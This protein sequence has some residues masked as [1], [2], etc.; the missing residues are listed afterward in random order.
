MKNFLH[1]HNL[2]QPISRFIFETDGEP[3]LQSPATIEITF[4][5]QSQM[6]TVAKEGV[7]G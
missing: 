4:H 1:S 5:S 7:R 6:L 2:V 3:C